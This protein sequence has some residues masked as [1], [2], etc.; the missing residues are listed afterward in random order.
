MIPG[1][2]LAAARLGAHLPCRP[3][4]GVKGAVVSSRGLKI[5]QIVPKTGSERAKRRKTTKKKKV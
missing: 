2:S 3:V 1:R 5:K 4:G